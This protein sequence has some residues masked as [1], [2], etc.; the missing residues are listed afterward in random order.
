M[1][2]NFISYCAIL[3]WSA[4]GYENQEVVSCPEEE[5]EKGEKEE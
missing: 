3:S 1:S 5:E 2:I 4:D